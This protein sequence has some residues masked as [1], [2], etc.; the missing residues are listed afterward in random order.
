[1]ASLLNLVPTLTG[2]NWSSWE[3]LMKAYL[4]GQD[5]WMVVYEKPLKEVYPMVTT[6]VI[7]KAG[8]KITQTS[9]NKS[10]DPENFEELKDWAREN[11]KALGSI[12]LRLSETIRYK[13]KGEVIAKYLWSTLEREFGRPGI[14]ATYHKFKGALLVYLPENNDPSVALNKLLGHFSRMAKADCAIPKHLQC[15]ILLAKLSSS[16]D[17]LAQMICQTDDIKSLEIDKIQRQIQVAWEQKSRAQ[18][19][20]GKPRGGSANKLSTVKHPQGNPTFQQQLQ[21]SAGPSKSLEQQLDDNQS[22]RGQGNDCG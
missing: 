20:Q 14:T 9:I 18:W 3:P 16:M 7:N 1:M 11:F 22:Q 13:F 10:G 21:N 8:E 19:F 17:G 2:Q 4:Q 12:N 15:L 6:E 5:Q